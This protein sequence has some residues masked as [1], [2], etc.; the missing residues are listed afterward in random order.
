MKNQIFSLF[1]VLFVFIGST[2]LFAQDAFITT[3]KTTKPA[4]S[5]TIPTGDGTFDYR[6]DWGD[7]T[8][9]KG[10]TTNAT[11]RY[12]L[13]GTY[14]VSISGDF[15]HMQFGNEY[16]GTDN[17][18]IQSVEQWGTQQ[19]RSMSSM[20]NYCTFLVI[21]AT[22]VPNLSNVTDMSYMFYF[23]SSFNQD[24]SGWDVSNVTDMRS[25]FYDADSFNQDI[26]GWDVSNVTNMQSMF[27][28][29]DSFNQDISDWDVSKVT[30]M[31]SMF[32][33]ATA[34][35]QD[36]SGWDVSN[37]TDMRYMFYSAT[38]F[39][40]NLGAWTPA[41][42][43]DLQY[44]FDYSGLSAANYD[45]LL[46]GWSSKA[47]V[48]NAKF[49]VGDLGYCTAETERQSIIATFGWDIT[50]GGLNCDVEPPSGY[51]VTFDQAEI[52][53]ANKYDA[54]FTISGGEVGARYEYTITSSGDGNVLRAK[55]YGELDNQTEQNDAY[56]FEL[57][58]GILTL[59]LT[60]IDSNNNRGNTVRATITKNVGNLPVV[61]APEPKRIGDAIINYNANGTTTNNLTFVDG[62]VT[63]F[64][65]STNGEKVFIL[66]SLGKTVTELKLGAPYAL[67]NVL[68]ET[69]YSLDDLQLESDFISLTDIS[70]DAT[71]ETMIAA[72]FDNVH[73][74]TLKEAFDLSSVISTVTPELFQVSDG[75]FSLSV[76]DNIITISETGGVVSYTFSSLMNNIEEDWF[77]IGDDI[78]VLD[79]TY[80][81]AGTR[82]FVLGGY[83]NGRGF[84]DMSLYEYSLVSPFQLSAAS[85]L[86]KTTLPNMFNTEYGS[87][88]DL[89]LNTSDTKVFLSYVI[90]GFND[91]SDNRTL[92]FEL[93]ID[94]VHEFNI[95]ENSIQTIT[96][97]DVND[98]DGGDID[99]NITY[100]LAASGD[101]SDSG[102][103]TINSST[104]ALMFSIPP[105][106][107]N[108]LDSDEDNRYEI[109]VFAADE[110]GSIMIPLYVV[111]TDVEN[112]TIPGY[113]VAIDQDELG[114]ENESAASFTF[115]NAQLGTTYNYAFTSAVDE[116]VVSGTGI[117]TTKSGQE[118]RFNLSEFPDGEITLSFFLSNDE[119]IAATVTDTVIKDTD[120]DDDG[121]K[122]DVDNC[123]ETA[124]NDQLDTDKDGEGDICDTDDDNDNTPDTEDAFPLDPNEDTDT[125]SDGVGNNA[126]AFPNDAT[127]DTDTDEDGVGDNS[128]AFPFDPNEDTDTDD[129]GVGDNADAFP[130]DASEDT[131]TDRDGVGD[132]SDVFP[133]NDTEDADTDN[134]GVGDNSD[135]YPNDPDRYS[136]DANGAGTTEGSSPVFIATETQMFTT[137]L[138]TDAVSSI[139]NNNY[140]EFDFVTTGFTFSE[141]GKFVFLINNVEQ[142]IVGLTL[143]T[144]YDLTTVENRTEVSPLDLDLD[145]EKVKFSDIFLQDNGTN[146]NL[147]EYRGIAH[148]VLLE[149]AYDL[150][151]ISSVNTFGS[152]FSDYI[153]A[154]HIAS[155]GATVGVP[156][157]IENLLADDEND[158]VIQSMVIGD[159]LTVFD[160]TYNAIGTR[161]FVLTANNVEDDYNESRLYEYFLSTPYDISTATLVKE[162]A[163]QNTVGDTKVI[164]SDLNFDA[165]ESRVFISYA[166]EVS[167]SLT[168]NGSRIIEVD[169][170]REYE[171][172]ENSF[173]MNVNIDAV[174]GDGGEIDSNLTYTLADTDDASFFAIN[175]SNGAIT[176]RELLDFENPQDTNEDNRYEL[177]VVASNSE[178]SSIL[179]L[180]VVVIDVENDTVPGYSVEIDQETITTTNEKEVSFSFSNAQPGTTYNFVF[181]SDADETTVSGAGLVTT[182]NGQVTGINL[183]ALEDGNINLSF[184]LS[185]ENLVA[186][187]VSD[188]VVKN[189]IIDTDNDGV[190]DSVDN[191]LETP[192]SDQLDSDKDGQGDVCDADDDN[193][194]TPDTEDAFPLDPSE[195]TDTDG[196]GVGDNAD[197]F[198]NDST[199][200]ADTDGDGVGDNADDFPLDA[201]ED[202]DTD[203]DGVRDNADA[204][205]NDS[206]ED[207]DTDGDGVGDN[208]DDFPLDATEDTD[209]DG[210]GMG[211]NTDPFPNDTDNDGV[212]NSE[213]ACP[214]TPS[215]AVVDVT[216]CPVFS[217]PVDNFRVKT[218]GETCVSGN[219][220]SVAITAKE[221]LAYTATIT[222]NSTE[223]AKE[224]T[225]A[226]LFSNLSSGTYTV[227]ITLA[228]QPNYENCFTVTVTQ[229]EDLSVSSKVASSGKSV[230][231]SLQGGTAYT[232]ELN[233]IVYS[234]AAS[235]I[236]LP[237]DEIENTIKV[238]TDQWC[239]GVFEETILVSSEVM[240]YPN[241]I[242]TGDLVI[243]IGASI[244]SKA[245][246]QLFTLNGIKVLEKEL[247][248]VSEKAY[249][250]VDG[251]A[252]GVYMLNV[253]A[254]GSIT[255]FKIIKK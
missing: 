173:Q 90:N 134:D 51:S 226:A 198:P 222:G 181:S 122:D 153:Y 217:L 72:S 174:D 77:F 125:D 148:T 76:N 228:A 81:K 102:F 243:T 160:V 21:N 26:S 231:L 100:S 45:T 98:G 207:T 227:C 127:E 48:A 61:V 78:V 236:T 112:D 159:N 225:T 116:S 250:N 24:I 15:P 109:Q 200:D 96:N 126:D 245:Q 93:P 12:A 130:N 66:S 188:T 71:G 193:D 216:G 172:Q 128:D 38:A 184:N 210:D 145:P 241:P 214:N 137:D 52:N 121:V 103:F 218:T 155:N 118:K 191:C 68:T 111:V 141:N 164:Y 206:T 251:F 69:T 9:T 94:L 53:F 166:Q 85:L 28:Y 157:G 54:S 178:T 55:G 104:G 240:V 168:S 167:E 131:D 91:S 213:D 58:N 133:Y 244:D 185:N 40:Q 3:W 129:D 135:A 20:F 169:A 74:I 83:F 150:N 35:N 64:T 212:V 247:S 163:L 158:N 8:K 47:L 234:T 138:E 254:N 32:W 182:E 224:F 230:T 16:E 79:I 201:T 115:S 56:V 73:F 180:R 101:S 87:F 7:G 50:D 165:S 99:A 17:L 139:K 204:F 114:L 223:V 6:V 106:F 237:L 147:I 161:L 19:W 49:S 88:T 11:H 211:D 2:S 219:N 208:A 95:Q 142:K 199:E 18:Q 82:L 124:N 70:F 42:A 30:N 187:T 10:H 221:G 80:N 179:P 190:L 92:I 59:E 97:I 197:A 175:P 43:N 202:T 194:N 203:G 119:V 13:P 229:P 255:S 33:R 22:D 105:D 41:K 132:N 253:R 44:M 235:S 36:I 151:S 233:G 136:N 34:F 84:S 60:L 252:S 1:L 123:T 75:L 156:N 46:I 5:I 144:A 140:I 62:L 143:G 248:I 209:T 23:A 27:D 232:V 239:Q 246:V 195:D 14:T 205:P 31:N 149:T 29:A 154:I 162:V 183:K 4:E 89:N 120:V 238:S 37:V 25:M 196:D 67:A 152:P 170:V 192:N 117:V 63:G 110:D 113:S 65:F 249:L 107:E 57:E 242:K 220:G 177:T 176:L 146:I 39:N 86:K 189:T 171:V 108:P 215:D 186:E